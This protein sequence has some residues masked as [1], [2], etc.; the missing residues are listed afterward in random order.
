MISAAG[1]EI[2][3]SLSNVLDVARAAQG[4]AQPRRRKIGGSGASA[5][6]ARSI[7][8]AGHQVGVPL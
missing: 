5:G 6:N 1:V 3:P 4:H 8:A 7:S 2:G